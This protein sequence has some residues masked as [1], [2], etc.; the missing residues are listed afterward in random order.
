MLGLLLHRNF[1]LLCLLPRRRNQNGHLQCV[2]LPF[3]FWFLKTFVFSCACSAISSDEKMH[4]R[5]RLLLYLQEENY[6]VAVTNNVM[7]VYL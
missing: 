1:I 5:K 2:L 6:Q 4:L 7:Q 3:Y